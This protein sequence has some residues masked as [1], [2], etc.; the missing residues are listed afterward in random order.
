MTTPAPQLSRED[1]FFKVV[2]HLANAGKI[3]LFNVRGEFACNSS[4]SHSIAAIPGLQDIDMSP[5]GDVNVFEGSEEFT[6]TDSSAKVRYLAAVLNDGCNQEVLA[7]VL[8]TLDETT[9]PRPFSAMGTPELPKDAFG[10]SSREFAQEFVEFLKRPD[11]AV[12]SGED[13]GDH[14]IFSSPSAETFDFSL[15]SW[16]ARRDQLNGKSWW[17]LFN[18]EDGTKL[19]MNFS[20]PGINISVEKAQNPELVDIKVTDRCPFELD[21]GFCYM[22]ST[23]QGAEAS[24]KHVSN[25]LIAYAEMGVFE[26]AFGGGEPTLWPPFKEVLAFTRSLGI[27]PNFTS[28]NFH[29]MRDEGLMR[30]VGAVAFSITDTQSFKRFRKV[31]DEQRVQS[32]LHLAKVSIQIIPEIIE[33]SLLKEIFAYADSEHMRLTLLGYKTTGRGGEFDGRLVRP[34]GFWIPLAQA[35]RFLR[36]AIDATLAENSKDAL[37]KARVPRWSYHLTEGSFSMYADAVTKRIGPSSY[38]EPSELKPVNMDQVADLTQ[39]LRENFRSY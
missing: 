25:L 6:L 34:E 37:A 35:H 27:I 7:D 32:N 26:V 15:S 8:K 21:C 28:K 23:R 24:L 17:V 29:A 13:Y 3:E 31:Y 33:D 19:R 22:G 39:A 2:A 16:T 9:A 36:L 30:N 4:S 12:F 1:P 10:D 18:R 11:V 14:P 20:S 38:V 5:Y